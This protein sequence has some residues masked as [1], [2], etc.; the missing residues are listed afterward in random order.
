MDQS[1]SPEPT[2]KGEKL[3]LNPPGATASLA[4][5]ARQGEIDPD[6]PVKLLQTLLKA[7]V[8]NPS[9]EKGLIDKDDLTLSGD[10]TAIHIHSD[11][12][13]HHIKEYISTDKFD[14]LRRYSD[15]SATYGFDSDLGSYYFGYTGYL[16]GVHSEADK[17]DLPVSLMIE[18]ARDHDSTISIKALN[19]FRALYPEVKV[20]NYCLDS[21]SD[22]EA[23]FALCLDWNITP[24]IDLNGRRGKDRKSGTISIDSKGIPHCQAGVEMDLAGFD[25]TH[26]AYKYRC[27]LVM[28]KIKEC[29]YWDSCSRTDYGRTYY[30]K[31]TMFVKRQG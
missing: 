19:Q 23:T 26:N 5:Q 14:I 1:G 24:V 20:S 17:I 12:R 8:V 22:N 6:R 9:I 16:L 2:H 4:E 18:P 31:C 30:Q 29:P 27:P 7:I 21:A 3:N 11:A 15:P 10:G 13:C 25:K 28:K